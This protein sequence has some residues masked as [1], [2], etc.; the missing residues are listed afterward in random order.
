MMVEV[1][2]SVES[3]I[4][5]FQDNPYAFLY[6]EDIRATLFCTLRNR[7]PGRR[8]VQGNG[9]P[10]N[11]YCLRSIYCEYGGKIDIACLKPGQ[12]EEHRASHKGFDTFI[13]NLPV[14]IGIELKYRKI[15]DTF[16]ADKAL[17]DYYKLV[18]IGVENALVLAFIQS[19]QDIDTF[20][21]SEEPENTGLESFSSGLNGVF[22]I[23]RS[24][25]IKI[26]VAIE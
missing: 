20:L 12:V 23:S 2:N 5:E 8:V 24:K 7:I 16:M 25:I 15:G 21:G 17:A 19:E 10:E 1:Q 3:I 18:R 11:E 26:A 14:E 4:R 13:Y 22:I 9:K 6:E